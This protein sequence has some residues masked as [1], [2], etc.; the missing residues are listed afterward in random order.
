MLIRTTTIFLLLTLA[1]PS[2][3][4]LHSVPQDETRGEGTP[5]VLRHEARVLLPTRVFH[6]PNFDPE[7]EHTLII[8][9]HGYGAS[10]RGFDRTDEALADMG[11]HVALPEGKSVRLLFLHGKEDERVPLSVS[12]ETRSIF[13]DAGYE[14]T[15]HPFS[16][17]HAVPQDQLEVVADWIWQ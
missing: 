4:R 5:V 2:G 8:G 13:S 11:F 17:G 9:F 10:A 15:F 16:G 6:P 14:A 3:A 12:E 1:S 7:R